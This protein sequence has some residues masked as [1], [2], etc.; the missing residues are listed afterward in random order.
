MIRFR[1]SQRLG[2]AI[3]GDSLVKNGVVFVD[4]PHVKAR[5]NSLYS[6][7]PHAVRTVFFPPYTIGRIRGAALRRFRSNDK[8]TSSAKTLLV[9]TLLPVL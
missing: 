8:L 6:Q 9:I 2:N 1:I 4:S 5:A 3:A 7:P